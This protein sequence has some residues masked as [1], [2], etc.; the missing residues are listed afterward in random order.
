M[1]V[2]AMGILRRL[3][4]EVRLISDANRKQQIPS[5]MMVVLLLP[6]REANSANR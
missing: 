3:G 4:L 5:V 1:M 2:S 6:E